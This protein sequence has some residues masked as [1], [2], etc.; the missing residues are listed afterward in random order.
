M[1][2][3]FSLISTLPIQLLPCAR[4][5]ALSN[6]HIHP[7][8]HISSFRVS[9]TSFFVGSSRASVSLLLSKSHPP[10]HA[11]PPISS[12]TSSSR[13]LDGPVGPKVL[14]LD[15]RVG[16]NHS[17]FSNLPPFPSLICLLFPSPLSIHCGV[18]TNATR[19][20]SLSFSIIPHS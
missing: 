17:H 4:A 8:I 13:P 10:L 2:Y 6:T 9:R 7:S 16:R 14:P 18:A 5:H 11:T 1:Y 15:C 3:Q 19:A 20:L 12:Q